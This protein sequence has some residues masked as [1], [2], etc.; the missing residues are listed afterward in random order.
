MRVNLET[1]KVEPIDSLGWYGGG[2]YT[3]TIGDDVY[4]LLTGEAQTNTTV[5][6]QAADKSFS[7]VFDAKGWV[8]R[9]LAMD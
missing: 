7:K 9:L 8:M 5:Y 2:Y 4:L 3:S 1:L 6:K